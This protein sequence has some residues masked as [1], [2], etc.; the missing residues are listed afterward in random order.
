[1]TRKEDPDEF[2]SFPTSWA[3]SEV[4]IPLDHRTPEAAQML[5]SPKFQERATYGLHRVLTMS[6]E[7][8][9][10]ALI[11]PMD[12][13]KK[14]EIVFTSLRLGTTM[15]ESLRDDLSL[16]GMGAAGDL[17]ASVDDPFSMSDAW[18][19]KHNRSQRY[20][21]LGAFH[22]HLH[23]TPFSD[24][25]INN[26]ERRQTHGRV[27]DAAGATIVG[28]R[29]VIDGLL[30]PHIVSVT[31]AR[32]GKWQRSV[33][34]KVT[35]FMMQGPANNTMYQAQ[36]GTSIPSQEQIFQNS[37]LT[38]WSIDLPVEDIGIANKTYGKWSTD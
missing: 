9:F 21:V 7:S 10:G 28:N 16:I 30:I 5:L 3:L 31:Q 24:Q 13:D 35:L 27:L 34:D 2:T 36:R 25:D 22:W 23:Y 8:A 20:M 26:Y 33:A 32:R 14:R 12:T 15:G 19:Q 37:G 4:S 11:G 18:D 1:M 38:T 6:A 29:H 17:T